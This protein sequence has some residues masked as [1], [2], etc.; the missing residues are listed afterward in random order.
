MLAQLL[1]L[2]ATRFKLSFGNLLLVFFF[3][4]S[5]FSD[6]WNYLSNETIKLLS[7]LNF[8]NEYYSKPVTDAMKRYKVIYISP[9]KF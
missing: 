9:T 6:F 4:S 1:V 7:E 3:L 8:Q 2:N 5:S